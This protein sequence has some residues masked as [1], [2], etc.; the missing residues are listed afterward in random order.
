MIVCQRARAQALRSGQI[1]VFDKGY[2]CR[3]FGR[4]SGRGSAPV[5]ASRGSHRCCLTTPR[6][7]GSTDR[8]VEDGACAAH[9]SIEVCT[10][11]SGQASDDW[12]TRSSKP[13]PGEFGR[14]RRDFHLRAC[15]GCDGSRSAAVHTGGFRRLRAEADG[16]PTCICGR[17][18]WLT[19][20]VRGGSSGRG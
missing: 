6:T 8:L 1:G 19:G 9:Q 16:H 10:Q 17:C 13:S 5:V 14:P 11:S 4:T 7:I 3:S 18:S 12:F 20:H 15:P 2:K